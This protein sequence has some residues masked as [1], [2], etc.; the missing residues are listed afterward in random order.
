M[1]NDTMTNNYYVLT[2]RKFSDDLYIFQDIVILLCHFR[3]I[4]L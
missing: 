4:H 1:N 2:N 3:D